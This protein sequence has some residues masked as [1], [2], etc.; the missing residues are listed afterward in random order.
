ME[1]D[2]AESAA[3]YA[4]D[5][6]GL[7]VNEYKGLDGKKRKAGGFAVTSN[8]PNNLLTVALAEIVQWRKDVKPP[9]FIFPVRPA[10][11]VP[12]AT[13]IGAVIATA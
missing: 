13:E 7:G 3:L 6:Y 4:M 5:A 11:L 9:E 1:K 12:E 2:A 8:D 10:F